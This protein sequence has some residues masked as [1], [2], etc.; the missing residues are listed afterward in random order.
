MLRP[1]ILLPRRAIVT[2]LTIVILKVSSLS[3]RYRSAL[4]FLKVFL[5]VS[6]PPLKRTQKVSAQSSAEERELFED[7]A[8]HAPTMLWV[9][10]ANG[11]MLFQNSQYLEFTGLSEE[12][13]KAPDSWSR[14]VHPDDIDHAMGVYVEALKNKQSFSV[15]YRLRRCDGEYRDV[16]DSAHPRTNARGKFAGYVGSTIDISDRKSQEKALIESTQATK[17]RS[18]DLNLLYEL[19]SDLQVCREVG[20]TKPVLSK[21]CDRLFPGIAAR[22]YLH[23]NSRDLVEP[24]VNWGTH[25]SGGSEMFS[26]TECWALRKGKSHLE[27][28]TSLGAVCPNARNCKRQNYLCIPMVAFGETVGI[29]QLDMVKENQSHSASTADASIKALEELGVMAADEI[30]AAI[31]ELKLRAR[32]QHQSTRDSLTHLYNRRY[33]M[34]A[35]ERELYRAKHT[36]HEL[37]V[38]MFDLDYFK[39]FNDLHGH[40]GGDMVLRAFGKV[41]EEA[42]RGGDVA[43]RYGGEEFAV[44]MIDCPLEG[45]R[46]RADEI[47]AKMKTIALEFHGELLEGVTTSVGISSFPQDGETIDDLISGADKALYAAKAN[48]RN[49]VVTTNGQQ[50]NCGEKGRELVNVA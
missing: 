44:L 29:M 38:L 46:K 43:S 19:K 17:K 49:C 25:S 23:N 48:G 2:V 47:C 18:R 9:S 31:E 5:R 26:P 22:V 45:A 33:F 3:R 4:R 27:Q 10:D 1:A 24:F 40:I 35:I 42:T 16:L 32:L 8:R 13:A 50:E 21:Y 39:Q 28:P 11:A 37:S 12:M 7:I 34:E 20:E 41:L 30:A 14:Q 15:E 6:R 36:E